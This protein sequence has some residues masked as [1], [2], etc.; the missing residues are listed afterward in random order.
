[1]SQEL[2]DRDLLGRSAALDI[3]GTGAGADSEVLSAMAVFRQLSL[4]S[5]R[6]FVGKDPNSPL[7]TL[8]R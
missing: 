8:Y 3:A 1:M 2:V 7:A 4:G 6:S 5:R